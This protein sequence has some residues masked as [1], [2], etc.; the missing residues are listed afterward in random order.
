VNLRPAPTA[1]AAEGSRGAAAPA[2][3]VVLAG[4][5]AA[6]HVAKLAPAIGALQAALQ[7]TLPQAGFLLSLVQL[8][9]MAGG[10]LLGLAADRI[11]ARRSLITGLLILAAA[12]AAGG[13]MHSVAA[14]LVLR[15]IEGVGFLLVVLPAPGLVRRLAAPGRTA[16]M[17]GLWGSYMPLATALVLLTGPLLVLAIGWRAWWWGLAALTLSMALWVHRAVPVLPPAAAAAPLR[18]GQVLQQTL[19]APG[20]WLVA[21]AFGAYSAQWLSVVGFLPTIYAQ[22]G[23]PPAAN[24]ALTALAAAAN[25]A[26]NVVAGRLLQRGWPAPRLLGI[27]FGA[28]A[29]AA[30]PAFAWPTLPPAVPYVALLVFSGMGGL[31]PATLFSLALRVAPGEHAVAS[32][33]GWMQQGSAL[34]QFAGP[35]VVAAL[36]ATVGGW[37]LTWIVTVGCATLG[38]CAAWALAR[39]LG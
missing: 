39:R 15:A 12:S 14:L 25:I 4:V 37:Q 13:A 10:L 33:V 18:R 7:I 32:T 1:I 6:L 21:A 22:A 17:L 35:P 20:P 19:A 36:A 29:L 24:G 11:G 3:L 16:A 23:V 5:C 28:M 9:G 27:G 34:G 38:G 31:I 2:R 8:A 30:V 26:G